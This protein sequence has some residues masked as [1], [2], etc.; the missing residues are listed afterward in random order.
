[1]VC[2]RTLW[3][4]LCMFLNEARLHDGW[5]WNCKWR[6]FGQ[7]VKQ[8]KIKQLRRAPLLSVDV[9]FRRSYLVIFTTAVTETS[10]VAVIAA[11]AVVK[12]NLMQFVSLVATAFFFFEI[13][14]LYLDSPLDIGYS[15]KW[16]RWSGS[17][18]SRVLI[19]FFKKYRVL[20]RIGTF[21]LGCVATKVPIATHPPGASQ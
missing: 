1:M 4:K 13:Q 11:P 10:P 3:S 14:L 6:F 9:S 15:I 2:W 18:G 20:H 17:F 7:S 5:K 16:C 21:S 8:A 12:K 19:S